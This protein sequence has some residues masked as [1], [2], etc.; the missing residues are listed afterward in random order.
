MQDYCSLLLQCDDMNTL[1]YLC[2]FCFKEQHIL[3]AKQALVDAA[4]AV[5]CY[6]T[7][8]FLFLSWIM[9]NFKFAIL[10]CSKQTQWSVCNHLKNSTEMGKGSCFQ[11]G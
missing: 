1:K 3:A 8:I 2:F 10:Y 11:F 4:N 5:C 6:L 7:A 9:F